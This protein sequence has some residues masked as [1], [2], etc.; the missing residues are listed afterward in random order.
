MA[1]TATPHSR[2]SLLLKLGVVIVILFSTRLFYMQ[3]VQHDHYKTL[4]SKEQIKSQIIPATRGEIYA[5]DG[6]N[7]VKLVLNEAVYT[8]FV[9]PVEVT[10]PDSIVAAL[11]QIAGGEMYDN[12]DMLVRDK[13]KRYNVLAKNITLKQAELLK[14]KKLKGLG[15]QKTVRRVY[16]EGQL[17]AQTLGFVNAEENGQYGVEEALQSELKGKDGL[18]RS[19]TDVANIPLTI[20]KNNT[21]I[22]PKNGKN[23]VL[24]LDRNI[25]SYTEKA[26]SDGMKRVGATQ[27]SVVVVDPQS[28]RVMAMANLP[29]YVPEKFTEVK[30][31]AVFNN[32]VISS[33]YEPG[34]VMKTFTVATGIDKGVMSPSSTYTN[35]DRISVDDITIGNATKGQTGVITIQHALNWSLNTGMVTVAQRLGNGT[36]INRQARNTIYDY[37]HNRFG[38]GEKTGIELAGEAAGEIISPEEVQGNAV[39]YSNMSFGQ[40]MNPTMLQVAAGFSSIING[41]HYYKPTILAGVVDEGGV[42]KPNSTPKPIRQTISSDAS[43]VAKQMV[44][45]ARNAFYS[46]QDKAGYDI[47]GKTGTSQTLINGSYDN[48]QTVGSYLGYGGD[49]KPRYVIMVQV[50]A[51]GKNL[52]GNTDAMPIFTDIS[53]WMIDYMKLQPQG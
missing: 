15:F 36:Y 37:F 43:K 52:A 13:P 49:T 40:G 53:N 30:D 17:A 34:S 45:D 16:P 20:G 23:F 35:T 9:D 4:A 5:L 31:A 42:F 27:G 39:R 33:P 19:V 12:V 1:H 22:A 3:V 46:G 26:L 41:G 24:S 25:Q 7:P 8:V 48:S 10:Q 2:I 11:K 50:S 14:S 44:H 29:T 18:R 47:G 21:E 28:G 38:L 51:D 32:A 6:S